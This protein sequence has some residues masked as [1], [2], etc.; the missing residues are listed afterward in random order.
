MSTRIFQIN[1]CDWWAGED[2]ESVK[3][4]F[5]AESGYKTVTQCEADGLI[6]DPRPLSEEELDRLQFCYDWPARNRKTS[7]RLR[8]Q[9]LIESQTPMPC[10]FASTEY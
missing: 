10:V 8:L 5:A 7:F 2:L 1:D 9:E 3:A 4:A 6:D